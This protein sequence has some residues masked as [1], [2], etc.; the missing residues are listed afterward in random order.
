LDLLHLLAIPNN[1]TVAYQPMRINR[2]RFAV[3]VSGH[4]APQE[5]DARS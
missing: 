2:L 5:P 4:I 1:R 3:A